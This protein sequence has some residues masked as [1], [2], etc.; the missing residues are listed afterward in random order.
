MKKITKGMVIAS[1]MVLLFAGN[2]LAEGKEYQVA[3]DQEKEITIVNESELT[4]TEITA[5]A[6]EGETYTFTVK[7]ED[8][9]AYTFEKVRPEI[10]SDSRIIQEDDFYFIEYL[11]LNSGKEMTI[12]QTGEKEY[13][14]PVTCYAIDD[15]YL[16][17]DVSSESEIVDTIYRGDE[18]KVIGETAKYY[19][20]EKKDKVGYSVKSCV[21][22]DEQDAINAVKQQE[23]AL[24]AQREAEEAAAYAQQG[25][26]GGTS[27]SG[28]KVVS[29]E[30]IPDC[31]DP[32]HG[33][34][35]ITYSDG[36]VGTKEY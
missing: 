36:S 2:A 15:V 21:S 5:S 14:E 24:E 8:G 12:G 17:A 27:S 11:S 7:A 19:K 1:G 6:E 16:R 35:Y 30:K 22:E 20:I 13:S 29:K 32:S 23:A 26:T 33:T 9:L 3:Y 4:I 34:I 25:A 18:I 31:S 28:K 10:M